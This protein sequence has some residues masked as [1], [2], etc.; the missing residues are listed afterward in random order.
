MP[1]YKDQ[2]RNTWYFKCRYTDYEGKRRQKMMRGFKLQREAAEAERKFLETQSFQP[3]MPFSAFLELYQNDLDPQ[4]REHTIM[5]RNYQLKRIMPYFADK[6]INAIEAKDV[7]AWHNALIDEG[8]SQSYIR[9]LNATLSAIFNHAKTFYGLRLNPC[10]LVGSPKVPDE[11]KK[12]KRFWTYE[13]FSQVIE[14]IDDLKAK[15]AVM[16]LYWSGMRKGELLALQW[17]KIDFEANK[18]T[19]DRSL[20]RLRGK[21]VVT[22]TKTSEPRTIAMPQFVMDQLK[23]YQEQVYMPKADDFVFDWEKRF[24]ENGM[25]QGR[26]AAGVKHI[27]VHELRHSHASLLISEGVNVVLISKRLGHADVSM[28]LNTYSHFFPDDEDKLIDSLEK[29][30]SK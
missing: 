30:V 1:V 4:L 27:T 25:K 29:L 20:Q 19:I 22:P 16:L 13:E 6:P 2:K 15:T 9:T 23:L 3:D 12:E 5:R 24:I 8:L 10:K 21:S 7:R 18:I 17:S 26:T 11:E 14:N 28:T